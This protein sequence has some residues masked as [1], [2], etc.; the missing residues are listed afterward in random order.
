MHAACG[1]HAGLGETANLD[2]N[3]FPWLDNCAI[4]VYYGWAS[5][6][7]ARPGAVLP[8]VVS[9][10]Y[11]PHYGNTTKTLEVHIMDEFESD[12]YDSVL[13]LVLVGYIRPM[14]K[15][16]SLDALIAAID[17]DKAFAADKLAGDA[18]AELKA[19]AFFSAT[20]E[21]DGWQEANPD[22]PVFAA[23]PATAAETS[24]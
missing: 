7:A 6:P 16:D 11:N 4:G 3:S 13:N 15:Y 22:E 1:R 19:D 8:A 23:P 20:D 14:E 2:V 10:G 9:V 24:S 12:F 17:A 21:S 18:W 5:V